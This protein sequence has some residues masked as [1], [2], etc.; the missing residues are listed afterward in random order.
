MSQA[1]HAP[2]CGSV[3]GCSGDGLWGRRGSAAVGPHRT[4]S[5]SHAPTSSASGGFDQQSPRLGSICCFGLRLQRAP[6]PLRYQ[7]RLLATCS[8]HI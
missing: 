5:T 1:L 4:A 7:G 8:M 6:L 3:D 2:A